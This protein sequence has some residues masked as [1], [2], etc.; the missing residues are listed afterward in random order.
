MAIEQMFRPLYSI[1][2]VKYFYFAKLLKEQE[3]Y[4]LY[5]NVVKLWRRIYEGN[6]EEDEEDNLFWWGGGG[7][8]ATCL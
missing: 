4:N 1:L 6:Y 2:D 8:L 3:K 5:C 7:A